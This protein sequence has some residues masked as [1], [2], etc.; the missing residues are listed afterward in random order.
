MIKL[1]ELNHTLTKVGA[2]A[3]DLTSRSSPLRS[4]DLCRV[5]KGVLWMLAG[6]IEGVD[7]PARREACR[8]LR[9]ETMALLSEIELALRQATSANYCGVRHRARVWNELV[10]HV[11]P[12]LGIRLVALEHRRPLAAPPLSSPAAFT[13]LYIADVRGK[14]PLST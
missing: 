3:L 9:I 10:E 2:A 13:K 5:L 12:T 14:P 6:D 11:R 4:K 7:T 8:Q 1:I